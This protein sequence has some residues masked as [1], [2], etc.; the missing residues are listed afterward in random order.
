MALAASA[1]ALTRAEIFTVTVPVDSTAAS[2]NA[3]RDAA[4]LDGERRAFAALLERLTLAKDRG[5]F[6]APSDTTLNQVI[7]G[8]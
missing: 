3:A 6:P 8:F 4:R 7:I 1:S 5:R 2:A